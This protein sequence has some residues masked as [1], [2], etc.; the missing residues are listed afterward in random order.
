MTDVKEM[1]SKKI[2]K[3][4]LYVVSFDCLIKT[5]RSDS[6]KGRKKKINFQ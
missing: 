1:N 6:K 3:V 4:I 5:N 2:Y